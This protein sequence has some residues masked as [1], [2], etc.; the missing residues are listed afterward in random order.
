[1][2]SEALVTDKRCGCLFTEAPTLV[3]HPDG[4]TRVCEC[5]ACGATWSS[6]DGY[7]PVEI[8]WLLHQA[9]SGGDY[10]L[11]WRIQVPAEVKP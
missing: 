8:S 4:D 7:P 5:V 11:Q 3:Q 2:K 6:R 9:L 10:A 1:M